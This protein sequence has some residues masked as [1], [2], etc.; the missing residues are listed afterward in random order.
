MQPGYFFHFLLAA[1]L[2]F[3]P[4]VAVKPGHNNFDCTILINQRSAAEQPVVIHTY[5]DREVPVQ[6]GGERWN[7]ELEGCEPRPYQVPAEYSITSMPVS[8]Y[9][10]ITLHSNQVSKPLEALT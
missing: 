3:T 2:T 1:G 5:S 7:V 8:K 6:L 4:T 10:F 9:S